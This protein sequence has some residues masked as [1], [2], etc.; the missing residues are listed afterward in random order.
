MKL[1]RLRIHNI[2]SIEDATIDFDSAPLEGC[3]VFL[4]TGKTG[5][6]KSTILDSICLALY[7]TTPRLANTRMQGEAVESDGSVTLK[8]PRQLMRRNC[9]ECFAS[10]RFRGTNEAEYEATWA[11]ARAHRKPGRRL[12]PKSWTLKNIGTGTTLTKDREIEAEIIRATGLDFKQFCRTVM[13]AQGDFTRFLNS[14]DNEKAEI[15]EKITGAEI[16]SLI[17]ARIFQTASEKRCALDEMVRRR[18]E[19]KILSEEELSDR[20]SRLEEISR[21]LTDLEKRQAETEE[22]MNWRRRFDALLASL[23]EAREGV[24]NA[25]RRAETTEAAAMAETV[26]QWNESAEA[27]SLM[28]NLKSVSESRLRQEQRLTIL[29][30]EWLSLNLCRE[31]LI[32]ELLEIREELQRIEP[33]KSCQAKLE[34]AY[35]NA[36]L[37][38]TLLRNVDSG[39]RRVA[40]ARENIRK[41]RELLESELIPK[42]TALKEEKESIGSSAE[43]AAANLE[44]LREAL[45]KSGLKSR[46]EEKEAN[47]QRLAEARLAAELLGALHA[48][49]EGRMEESRRIDRDAES[50]EELRMKIEGVAGACDESARIKEEKERDL[51]RQRDTVDK[52]AT[53]MRRRLRPGDHCP[54]CG[55]RIESALP[56]DNELSALCKI[57]ADAA[58]K[59]RE[60]FEQLTRQRLQL[61]A[62]A[63]AL[64]RSI[65]EARGRL[66]KDEQGDRMRQRVKSALD[67]CFGRETDILSNDAEALEGLIRELKDS[68]ARLTEAIAEGEKIEKSVAEQTAVTEKL[69]GRAHQAET[70]ATAAAK[71]IDDC[72]RRIEFEHN[73]IEEKE[74][75]TR[76][77][78]RRAKI[79]SGEVNLIADQEADP[80]GA[81]EELLD[82]ARKYRSLLS[83]HELL[84]ERESVCA[85]RL[86]RLEEGLEGI[87]CFD[88]RSDSDPQPV[89][90]D[91]ADA[92]DAARKLRLAVNETVTLIKVSCEEEAASTKGIEQFM[93]EHE[94]LSAERLSVLCGISPERIRDLSEHLRQLREDLV[95]AEA[96]VVKAQGDVTAHCESRPG[97]VDE[98]T[99]EKAALQLESLRNEQRGLLE[100]QA[101]ICAELEAD[102]KSRL[103]LK[104]LTQKTADCRAEWEKWERLN[105]L[106]GERS[107]AKFR[108]IAQSY[109]LASLIEKANTYM[110]QLSD[111]YTLSVTAGSFVISLVDAYQGYTSRSAATISGGESFL[112]S[113]ALALALSDMG[114]RVSADTLFIDEGFGTLSGEPLHNAIET[115][116]SLHSSSGRQVGII[117]HV[118]ELRECLPVQIRVE[119]D[120]NFSSG[121]ITIVPET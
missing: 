61:E 95:S 47:E 26:S 62:E 114:T 76:E 15:L 120:G 30:G 111:R 78:G 91:V 35:E 50:L 14:P 73:I 94:E 60:A 100:C 84:K 9:G 33:E 42:T 77:C 11:A 66:A 27:R 5:A 112:V 80:T 67:K 121:R 16:Y 25:R 31:K 57:V 109:I 59:A 65:T 71:E 58:D 86:T 90:T 87:D 107:G 89:A 74:A 48:H 10:L 97:G 20:N 88:A 51:E 69:R 43:T 79:L 3:G 17:S 108:K 53:E 117:S 83:R 98:T 119:R 72:H 34:K 38:A 37:T 22:A 105:R 63:S 45:E 96:L 24:A 68:S 92:A 81:A 85:E 13:L 110:A 12:Q 23:A 54:V 116:R 118:R 8:D 28:A 55:Q 36:E 99:A 21:A 115:L 52:F 39:R 19:A 103:H 106:F 64:S 82:L 6:G 4:I 104:D 41:T 75:E 32:G 2:A 29:K 113:L 46:R 56:D 101:R 40:V 1:R 7:A 102:A 18:E 93:R 44:A 70:A 49:E